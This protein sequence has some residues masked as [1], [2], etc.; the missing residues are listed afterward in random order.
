MPEETEKP[1]PV[2]CKVYRVFSA[3]TRVDMKE[4]WC[5]VCN[6]STL[7]EADVYLLV[8][9]TGDRMG[10]VTSRGTVRYCKQ[11]QDY[12]YR[13]LDGVITDQRPHKEVGFQ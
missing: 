12:T 5:D 11:G 2:E 9:P 1:K 3:S 10:G 7:W 8:E 13:D 6:K 4:N